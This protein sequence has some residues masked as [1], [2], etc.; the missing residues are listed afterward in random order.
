MCGGHVP[1]EVLAER[2]AGR[3]VEYR[4][5]WRGFSSSQ[6]VTWELAST[7]AKVDGF[8]DVLRA[9]RVRAPPRHA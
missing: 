8:D 6:S 5:K 9:F 3:F 7:L 1:E 4:V 2:G